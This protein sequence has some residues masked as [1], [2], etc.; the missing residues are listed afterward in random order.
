[1]QQEKN[2]ENK[3]EMEHTNFV[4]VEHQTGAQG[5]ETGIT[6]LNHLEPSCSLTHEGK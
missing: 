6:D 3:K 4:Q 1:M 2:K 5:G